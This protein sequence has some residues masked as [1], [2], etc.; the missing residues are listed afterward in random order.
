MKVFKLLMCVIEWPKF[1]PFDQN[2]S[3][4]ID[5]K[6]IHCHNG[7]GAK[8]WSVLKHIRGI[9]SQ[10]N[11][12]VNTII[13]WKYTNCIVHSSYDINTGFLWYIIEK[14]FNID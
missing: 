8:Q 11:K 12:Q 9:T 7:Q 10:R 1:Q 6:T 2:H 14:A 4:F 5:N 13:E 3:T